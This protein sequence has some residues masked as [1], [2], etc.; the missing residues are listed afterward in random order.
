[1]ALASLTN[2]EKILGPRMLF[3]KL[4]FSIDRGERVG[5][6]GNNGEGKT[7]LFRVLLGEITPDAGDVSIQRARR[8]A[9]FSRTRSS[10]PA[11]R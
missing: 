10:H 5:L 4:S 2:I 9:S 6:I 1:M 8:W 11:T 3:E 7:T